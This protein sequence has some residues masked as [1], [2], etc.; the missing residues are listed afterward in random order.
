MASKSL[1]GDL[2]NVPSVNTS[3]AVLREQAN[4]LTEG[5]KGVLRGKVTVQSDPAGDFTE[6]LSVVAPSLDGYE[7]EVLRVSH[8]ITIYPL[9]LWDN[10]NRK[11]YRIPGEV[12]FITMLGA[13]LS[14]PEI[15]RVVS[16]LISQSKA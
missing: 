7:Y 3:K 12:E 1:W 10:V 9:D 11:S 16:T 6:S 15:R 14:S 13:I 2:E 5:T 4:A 8:G